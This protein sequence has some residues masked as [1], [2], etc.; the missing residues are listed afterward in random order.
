MATRL[1]P[2]F[3]A[4]I[5]LGDLGI[6]ESLSKC[7]EQKLEELNGKRIVFSRDDKKMIPIDGWGVRPDLNPT[8][9][10]TIRP[11]KENALVAAIDSSSANLAETE[12]GGWN[13]PNCGIPTANHGPPLM[14]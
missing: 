7:I 6:A 10:T 4:S 13:G 1:N 9:V 11:I 3:D 5:S 8:T 2:P 14:H 12:E